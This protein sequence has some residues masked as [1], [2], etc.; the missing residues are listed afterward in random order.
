MLNSNTRWCNS[1]KRRLVL[2][3]DL[4]DS[5]ANRWGVE[6][7]ETLATCLG[8][9]L[10]GML[11]EHPVFDKQVAVLLGDHVTTDAG[12]RSGAYRT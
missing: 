4:L 9:A 8:A 6:P 3:T 2:A 11:M 1:V 10:E 12:N 7:F 5:I